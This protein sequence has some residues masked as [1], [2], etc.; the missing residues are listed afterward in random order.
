MTKLFTMSFTAEELGMLQGALANTAGEHRDEGESAMLSGDPARR[1]AR[2]LAQ[3]ASLDDLFFQV[4]A[5]K[6]S[7]Q[8]AMGRR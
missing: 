8:A 5:M 3:A 7:T 1:A 2:A 4:E 6:A